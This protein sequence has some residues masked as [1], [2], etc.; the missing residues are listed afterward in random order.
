MPDKNTK[1]DNV[2]S[3]LYDCNKNVIG[4]ISFTNNITT[5]SNFSFTTSIGTIQTFLGS[6]VVNFSYTIINNSEF[7]P[8]NK[9]LSATPTFTSGIYS[10]FTNITVTVTSLGDINE[11]RVLTITY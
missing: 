4:F 6:L 1:I 2:F 8:K 3:K 11:T 5:L 9:N 7:L 10:N